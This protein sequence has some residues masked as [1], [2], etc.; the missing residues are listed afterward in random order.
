M[1]TLD[2]NGTISLLKGYQAQRFM[3]E[4]PE[5]GGDEPPASFPEFVGNVVSSATSLAT[6]AISSLSS[7]LT[8]AV[9]GAPRS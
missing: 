9:Q 8:A 7:W 3:G 1:L 5:L 6:T 4:F 2:L